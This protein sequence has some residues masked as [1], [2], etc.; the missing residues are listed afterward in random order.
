MANIP[1]IEL[2]YNFL[3]SSKG[4]ASF[5]DIW[6]SIK[7]DI[8]DVNKSK[9]ELI[10]ELYSD[11]VLDNRFALTSEG[12]WGLRDYLKF[13]DIKKQYD[14]IDK[15]ETTEEFDDID[16]SNT[17]S[18]DDSDTTN[19]I[20]ASKLKLSIDDDYDEDEEEDDEDFDDSDELSLTDLGEDDYDD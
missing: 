14:Y 9:N 18:Y 13:D 17:D 5:E 1:T 11:L 12:K 3:Q 19:K 10:A 4:D 7:N 6:N 8:A 20:D 2:A 15:F 16:Y